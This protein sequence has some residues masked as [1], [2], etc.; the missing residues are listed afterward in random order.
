MA[1]ERGGPDLTTLD[2]RNRYQMEVAYHHHGSWTALAAALTRAGRPITHAGLKYHAGLIGIKGI[3]KGHRLDA[4]QRQNASG[5]SMEAQVDNLADPV[6]AEAERL[7]AAHQARTYRV[8]TQ[9]AAR[10]EILIKAID[11]A[12]RALPSVTIEPPSFARRSTRSPMSMVIMLGDWHYGETVDPAQVMDLNAYDCEIAARRLYQLEQ[13][14]LTAL[15]IVGRAHPIPTLRIMVLGDMVS[16]NIHDLAETN[17]ADLFHQWAGVSLLLAQ[18][19]M[20]L[21][22]RFERVIVE[23]VPGNHGRTTQK[24]PSKN[25]Y[26]NWDY[27]AYHMTSVMVMNQPNVVCKF[28]PSIFTL[29]DVEGHPF[30]LYHG[31][32]IK[33]WSGIPFYGVQR[34]MAKLTELLQ[35]AGKRFE[36]AAIGHFHQEASLERA[37]GALLLNPC[38]VG[39]GEYSIG[40]LF[41]TGSPSQRLFFVHPEHGKT[42]ELSNDLSHGDL[43][44]HPYKLAPDRDSCI[45][46]T[47]KAL[48]AA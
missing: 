42:W 34:M 7:Q 28:P 6:A 45:G 23:G 19:I 15:D 44:P 17:D 20:R 9:E 48:A 38:L 46:E 41:V 47:V 22:S 36:Y 32:A 26:V 8:F 39:G 14:A 25:R 31:D 40:T 5:V 16:G 12:V 11:G 10:T 18:F 30:L 24:P 43:I 1:T 21:S 33:G 37:K 2:Y 35:S 27:L 29:T 3:G 4:Q 13:T